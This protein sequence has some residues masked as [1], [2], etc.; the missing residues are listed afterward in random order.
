MRV[1]VPELKNCGPKAAALESELSAINGITEVEC[2]IVTGSVIVHYNP[3]S[4][5]LA[6]I[7]K[8]LGCPKADPK[9]S[10]FETRLGSK[11]T[12][13]LLMFAL[14]KAIERAVPAL[15]ASFL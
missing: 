7:R 3:V 14:E 10:S 6:T 5:D 4:A 15:I 12:R 2:H 11:I 8:L 13:D 1:R 9:P